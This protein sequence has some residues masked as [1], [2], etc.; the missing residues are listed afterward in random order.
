MYEY[1]K[2]TRNGVH[3]H[4]CAACVSI[5]IYPIKFLCHYFITS[6]SLPKLELE[7]PGYIPVFNSMTFLRQ[8]Y[9]KCNKKY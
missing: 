9:E 1:I 4:L 8:I 6:S 7:I 5:S 2:P 3:H